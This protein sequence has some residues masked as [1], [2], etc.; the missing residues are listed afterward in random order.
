MRDALAT[1]LQ[2]VETLVEEHLELFLATTLEQHVPVG[3][4]RLR[5]LLLGLCALEDRALLDDAPR[6][7]VVVAIGLVAHRAEAAT[8]KYSICHE[9]F[10]SKLRQISQFAGSISCVHAA[11][12]FE[13][14]QLSRQQEHSTRNV[15][16]GSP[17]AD[18]PC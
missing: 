8:P 18:D 17:P 14:S 3:A 6:R 4:R 16:G 2:Q 1:L 5:L 12:T 10:L 13:R 11:F 15:D 9:Q 7:E